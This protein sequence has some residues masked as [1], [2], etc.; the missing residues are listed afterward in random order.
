MAFVEF[1]ASHKLKRA[2]KNRK[3]RHILSAS[4]IDI[5]Q[6]DELCDL[7]YQYEQGDTPIALLSR[8]AIALLFFQSSTRTRAGFQV[9]TLA[10]GSNVVG[11]ENM[12][13]SR[14]NQRSG[15][16]LEDCAAVFSR[17]CD[18]IVIRHHEAGAAA[19]MA[20]KS[21][22]PVI[23]AGDG[24]NEHPTQALVDIYSLRRGLGTIKGRS[25]AFGGD[26]RGRTVRSLILLL[27]HESPK[28]IV[29]CPPPHVP[30]PGDLVQVIESHQIRFRIVSSIDDALV[31]CDA[32]MMAPYD[33][34]DIGEAANSD[35]VSPRSTP[36]SHVITSEKIESCGS[37]SLLYHPLP[38][39]DEIHPSCDDLD[40]A[41]YFEQVRLSKFMRM[42]ILSNTVMNP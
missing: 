37:R 24:W 36:S 25:I 19:R 5:D 28:E 39:Q 35:Y 41:M 34:S 4:T 3:P 40:Q 2:Q 6:V 26:P 29:F 38:R 42:A 11:F 8:K 32:V 27:R 20:S 9:A 16:T 7:A 13:A 31:Q 23:N 22:C 18:A 21:V 1:E 10:L 14:S 30:L 12:T 33:M 15:E 17:L